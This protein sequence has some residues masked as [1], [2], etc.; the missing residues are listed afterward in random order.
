[1]AC[2]DDPM[3]NKTSCSCHFNDLYFF[4]LEPTEKTSRASS[5]SHPSTSSSQLHYK[6]NSKKQAPMDSKQPIT[7]LSKPN[8]SELL[9]AEKKLSPSVGLQSLISVSSK[10][11]QKPFGSE[12][13]QGPPKL[14]SLKAVSPIGRLMLNQSVN[15]AKNLNE[16]LVV[17]S[18]ELDNKTM[19]GTDMNF[20]KTGYKEKSGWKSSHKSFPTQT[21]VS[22][23]FPNDIKMKDQLKQNVSKLPTAQDQGVTDKV[24]KFM[25]APSV[26]MNLQSSSGFKPQATFPSQQFISQNEDDKVIENGIK[27]LQRKLQAPLEISA[28]AKSIPGCWRRLCKERPNTQQAKTRET[29]GNRGKETFIEFCLCS[30]LEMGEIVRRTD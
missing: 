15:L 29:I 19:S 26:K 17:S 9:T 22:A 27:A 20:T 10:A 12:N 8:L 23:N 16:S 30:Y 5:S 2:F 21:G 13:N 14:S 3:V 28:V 25:L 7:F 1:M 6:A 18:H 24:G 4:F 11:P